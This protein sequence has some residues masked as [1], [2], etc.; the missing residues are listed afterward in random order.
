MQTNP[1]KTAYVK[2]MGNRIE[3]QKKTASDT[4]TKPVSTGL[5]GM[6]RRQPVEQEASESTNRAQV[7]FNEIRD[8]RKILNNGRT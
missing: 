2:Y 5:M 4:T 8:Q 6:A 1:A 7:M 3:A